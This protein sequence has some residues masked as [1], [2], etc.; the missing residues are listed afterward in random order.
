[1]VRKNVSNASKRSTSP[2]L[3]LVSKLPSK[4][5][6]QTAFVKFSTIRVPALHGWDLGLVED[7]TS[8]TKRRISIINTIYVRAA[9]HSPA[10]VYNALVRSEGCG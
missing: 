8:D 9:C 3:K 7:A 6:H 4:N 10:M 2:H 1:M 5:I